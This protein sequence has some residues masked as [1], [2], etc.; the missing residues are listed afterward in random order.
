VKGRQVFIGATAAGSSTDY[1]PRSLNLTLGT[2]FKLVQGFAGVAPIDLAFQR[3]EIDG[4]CAGAAH[5]VDRSAQLLEGANPIGRLIV[6]TG[7]DGFDKTPLVDPK[8]LVPS[9]KNV[10][11]DYSLAPNKDALELL[12]LLY[13]PQAVT[14]PW[15]VGPG[16]PADRVELLRAGLEKTFKDPAFLADAKAQILVPIFNS[17]KT[18]QDLM[19]KIMK[20]DPRFV[21]QLKELMK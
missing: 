9:L 4:Y 5:F 6:I 20:S 10:P 8:G 7:P 13:A 3:K 15:A 19:A 11:T 2:N 14:M 18:V 1:V 17:G 16:V 21:A 12:Q